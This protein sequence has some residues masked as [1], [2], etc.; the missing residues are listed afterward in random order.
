MK[1]TIQHYDRTYTV[2]LPDDCKLIEFYEAYRSLC[3]CVW[4][5]VQTAEIFN[6]PHA[7]G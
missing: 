6:E 2:E 5:E 1:I 7:E 3:R 4:T